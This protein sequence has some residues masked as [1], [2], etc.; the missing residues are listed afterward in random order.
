MIG[1]FD[2][3]RGGLYLLR[4][5]RRALPQADLLYFADTE[6]L[7]YGKKSEEEL[8]ALSRAAAR[9]LA[10]H[11]AEA[12]VAA[13]GT[14]SSTVL[15]RLRESFPLPLFGITEGIAE[16]IPADAEGSLL[17]L[18]TERTVS[19]GGMEAA[20]KARAPHLTVRARA[21]PRFVTLAER[22]IP[23]RD[24]RRA[25]AAVTAALRGL[26]KDSF[27][28]VLLGC[29]H[30]SAFRAPIAARFPDAHILDGAEAG[31]RA[32]AAA[33]RRDFPSLAAGRGETRFIG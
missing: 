9:L 1:L 25:A 30:F 12:V 5:L 2:S 23:A 17:L 6:N 20:I 7:P 24:P 14:V 4:A 15:P 16:A 18:A 29:T 10:A 8:L 11:G 3:G 27:S 32:I 26:E 21:C 13:C 31:A 22:E 19:S 28:Y 33:I